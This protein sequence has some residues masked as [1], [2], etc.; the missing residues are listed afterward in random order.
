MNENQVLAAEP[1]GQPKLGQLTQEMTPI[2]NFD[3]ALTDALENAFGD[4]PE[5]AEAEETLDVEDNSEEEVAEDTD[6]LEED[7]GNDEEVEEASEDEPES[8][9]EQEEEASSER[10]EVQEDDV[11]VID[12][13]EVSVKDGLLM[14]ADYTKKSQKLAAERA[15]FEEERDQMSEAVQT[16]NSLD[17][18]WAQSQSG[19]IATFLTN[20]DDVIDTVADAINELAENDAVDP[21]TFVVKTIVSLIQND[22]LDDELVEMLGF[23]E[24]LVSRM[25][26]EGKRDSRIRRL[27]KQAS[28]RE[29]SQAQPSQEEMVATARAELDSQWTALVDSQPTVSAMDTEGQQALKVEVAKMALDRGGIPLDIAYELLEA[30][31]AR[32]EAEVA[33]KKAATTD[34]KRRTRT[35][36]KPTNASSG[37]STNKKLSLDDAIAEAFNELR[38]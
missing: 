2:S 21:N 15:A 29:Q 31:R 7:T 27:E 10:F 6:V 19:T 8:E 1:Y 4:I 14:Q 11:L 36:S 38:G 17:E 3:T 33:K 28:A 35:V 25:K 20:S 18:S 22:R 32:S 5:Q 23:D 16:M 34:A 24:E 12:G 30:K 37:R 26:S 13:R 9:E